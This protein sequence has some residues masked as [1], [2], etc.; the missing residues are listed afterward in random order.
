MHAFRAKGPAP[1]QEQLVV[2][3]HRVIEKG[4]RKAIEINR[5]S[6]P[7]NREGT[8]RRCRPT[9]LITNSKLIHTAPRVLLELVDRRL[10][11]PMVAGQ[12]QNEDEQ[13]GRNH[14]HD[15]VGE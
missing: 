8:D 11:I 1:F 13:Q 9:S 10:Y 4:E 3:S 12:E 5:N 6:Q 14:N 15:D 2:N 7:K